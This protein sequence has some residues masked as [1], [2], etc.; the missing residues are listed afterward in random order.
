M[1]CKKCNKQLIMIEPSY[2]MYHCGTDYWTKHG[3]RRWKPLICMACRSKVGANAQKA[4]V[5]ALQSTLH[6]RQKED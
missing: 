3:Q 4:Q 5:S 6:K 2:T 1:N